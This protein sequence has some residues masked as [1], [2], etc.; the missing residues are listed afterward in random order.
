MHQLLGEV[1]AQAFHSFQCCLKL[2]FLHKQHHQDPCRN[3]YLDNFLFLQEPDAKQ[4]FIQLFHI[5][6]GSSKYSSLFEIMGIGTLLIECVIDFFN[7]LLCS[8]TNHFSIS[9]CM[10]LSII[11]MCVI[12]HQFATVYH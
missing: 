10:I 2:L 12:P 8:F 6:I 4:G 1:N 9:I 11:H 5:T 7:E 3:Q